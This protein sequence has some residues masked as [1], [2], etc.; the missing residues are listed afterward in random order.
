MNLL[1]FHDNVQAFEEVLTLDAR[2]SKIS[3]HFRA[4]VRLS[5]S[6]FPF[7]STDTRCPVFISGLKRLKMFLRFF[8]RTHISRLSP[9]FSLLAWRVAG[10][11][12]ASLL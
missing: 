12:Y 4:N 9:A 5:S 1:S 7:G 11:C 6:V 3:L 10:I 8:P 2:L